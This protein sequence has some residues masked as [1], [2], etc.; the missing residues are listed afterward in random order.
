[1]K[2]CWISKLNSLISSGLLMS[3]TL[4]AQLAPPERDAPALPPTEEKL[5]FPIKLL[6]P[7]Y[8]AGTMGEFRSTHFHAGIDIGTR[9]AIG[10]PVVAAQ[11]GYVSRVSVSAGGYG[12]AAYMTHPDGKVT[13]YGHLSRFDKPLADYVRREQYR[14]RSFDLDLYFRSDQFVYGQ[15]DTIA[16]SGN[17]GS[18]AGPHLHFEVRSRNP[19]AVNPLSQGF[20]EIT[21]HLPPV[22]QKVALRTLD[23]NSRINDKYGRFEFYLTKTATGY[24]LPYPILAHG[25]I[26]I[27]VLA[28]DK[29]DN[30]RA[31]TGINH[32]EVMVDGVTVFR[33]DINQVDLSQPRS[34]Y[35][36]MD[37]K[38]LRTS[39]S[40]F[41]KLYK[42]EGNRL[43]YYAESPGHGRI[44]VEGTQTKAVTLAMKDVAGHTTEVTLKLTPSPPGDKAWSLT[45]VASP[46]FEIIENVMVVSAPACLADSNRLTLYERGEALLIRP[47]YSANGRFVYLIDLRKSMPDSLDHCGVR[48]LS[49]LKARVPS[50]IEYTFYSD[51]LNV[52]FPKRSLVDT[53]YLS[54]RHVRVSDSLEVFTV[55]D[56]T[57]PLTG[58]VGISIKPA[59]RYPAEGRWEVYHRTRRN[60]Y[61][62]V[63]S[64]WHNDRLHFRAMD[65]GEFVLLPDTVPPT[66]RVRS[67]GPTGARL[68]ISDYRS[69]V[70]RYEA[71]LDGK[72][73]M[74]T[75]DAKTGTLQS[76]RLDP[77]E[78]LKGE[79]ILR[80]TDNAG[81]Q[82]IF[83]QKIS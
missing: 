66:I 53:L 82:R 55:G 18:S 69:G 28:Y 76:E 46:A 39:G 35:H 7:A 54:T 19:I 6:P 24:T 63:Y 32:F 17:T 4:A 65:L 1:M 78:P 25:N 52:T 42:D 38:A 21:D 79:F 31:R 33:Q 5:A 29:T 2:S 64:E 11:R 81:N 20:E 83:R 72:W 59:N 3:G 13:L 74:M 27:E 47:S 40:R 8:L 41:N 22:A 45:P 36:L 67:I 48:L 58:S 56:G 43:P 37:L 30:S 57:V 26:G 71:S 73:L 75:Y 62:Y 70:D 16:Y 44:R 12:Y 10:L 51:P 14:L 50:G 61:D 68:R 23:I 77:K 9:N 80:V 49:Y 15:G 60:N 34:I